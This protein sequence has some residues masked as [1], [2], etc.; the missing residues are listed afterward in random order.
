MLHCARSQENAG[1]ERE[2][3]GALPSFLLFNWLLSIR[4]IIASV[5]KLREKIFSLHVGAHI[6]RENFFFVKQ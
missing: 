1:K 2:R 5:V 3:E 6:I 4:L